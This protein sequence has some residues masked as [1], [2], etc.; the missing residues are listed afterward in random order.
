MRVPEVDYS[1]IIIV[2]IKIILRAIAIEIA[3]PCEL[4]YSAIVI[5]IL[6]IRTST[7]TVYI[8]ISYAIIIVIHWILIYSVPCSNRSARPRVHCV[9]LNISVCTNIPWIGSLG[10]INWTL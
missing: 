9:W 6:V 10:V 5:I 3:R 1:I 2:V 7:A 4:V 8:L